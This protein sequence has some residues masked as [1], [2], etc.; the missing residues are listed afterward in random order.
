LWVLAGGTDATADTAAAIAQA[1]SGGCQYA[2]HG[3]RDD[4]PVKACTYTFSTGENSYGLWQVNRD[5]HPQYSAA[6]LYTEL[7]NAKAAV[8][9]ASGGA[10]FRPWTTYVNGA[11]KRFLQ[12]GGTPTAQPG[13]V[14]TPD[15]PVQ[16]LLAM[17]GW[18]ELTKAL[19]YSVPQALTDSQKLRASALRALGQARTIGRN[20]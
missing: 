13:I 5:A 12:A 16:P 9:I 19:A 2:K 7:G 20:G 4:R 14:T 6:S 11:Y 1:E 18:H 3:P 17:H 8:E 10:N 15:V